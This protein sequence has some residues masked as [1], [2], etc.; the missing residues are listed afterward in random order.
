[1][2][3]VLQVTQEIKRQQC[4]QLVCRFIF[5]LM[6]QDLTVNNVLCSSAPGTCQLLQRLH[7]DGGRVCNEAELPHTCTFI[8]TQQYVLMSNTLILF[9]LPLVALSHCAVSGEKHV[10]EN[11]SITASLLFLYQR[12]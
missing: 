4:E 7:V 8:H 5:I 1:M 11:G 6:V 2:P 3:A 12:M 9:Q 10:H